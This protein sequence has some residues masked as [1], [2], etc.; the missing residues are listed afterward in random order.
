MSES[1]ALA[2]D[3][4]T[5]ESPDRDRGIGRYT[6]GLIGG[7]VETWGAP[8]HLFGFGEVCPYSGPG[9][10]DGRVIYHR[11]P[12]SIDRARWLEHGVAAPLARPVEGAART[13]FLCTSPA[14]PDVLIPRSAACLTGCILYDL[15]PLI[16]RHQQ[17]DILPPHLWEGYEQRLRLA[18]RMDFA[19]AIS[20]NT[21]RDAIARLDWPEPR[22]RNI[23]TGVESRFFEPVEEQAIQRALKNCGIRP[24]FIL[25]VSGY[26]PRKNWEGALAAYAA[27]PKDLRREYRFALVC[28]LTESQ[29][30][31]VLDEAQ[32]L[33][34]AKSVVITGFVSDADLPALYRGAAAFLFPSLYEGFGIP[35]AEAMACGCPTL[36]ADNSSLPEVVGDCGWM[37]DARD[38]QALAATL[39]EILSNRE[40]TKRKI[41][42]ALERAQQ[43]QWDAVAQRCAEALREFA[44]NA[45]SSLESLNRI[46]SN[47]AQP[48]P[49]VSSSHEDRTFERCYS[50][51]PNLFDR[52]GGRG[53]CPQSPARTSTTGESIQ[54][55]AATKGLFLF[56]QREYAT[57]ARV[58]WLR[59]CLTNIPET[60]RGKPLFAVSRDTDLERLLR[61][62]ETNGGWLWLADA[63][64]DFALRRLERDGMNPAEWQ[65]APEDLRGD[66]RRHPLIQRLLELA[67]GFTGSPEMLEWFGVRN[68]QCVEWAPTLTQP[69]AAVTQTSVLRRRVVLGDFSHALQPALLEELERY[70]SELVCSAA[71][72]QSSECGTA[73]PGCAERNSKLKE[74]P[75]YSAPDELIFIGEVRDPIALQ[76]LYARRNRPRLAERV[77]IM[78]A[79]NL[80]KMLE[81]A[82][83]AQETIAPQR[84]GFTPDEFYAQF[85]FYS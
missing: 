33:G 85:S 22:I 30:E 52:D 36:V 20:D 1:L 37:A 23:G 50:G 69:R 17:P 70:A 13:V 39:T 83:N 8:L 34:V 24:P 62:L 72:L 46:S 40:Q 41:G 19:L 61:Q 18:R 44:A 68:R 10:D 76:P 57:G 32:R 21:R 4:Q 74:K 48:P 38:P 54:R 11:Y 43:F 27:L 79:S 53:D 64:L 73:A 55:Q 26:N 82:H 2:L 12:D 15:I 67:Q 80:T 56:D 71:L 81:A 77:R 75:D 59:E 78:P 35:A 47:V 63:E 28:H 14:M 49:A 45:G 42:A 9:C 51:P 60:L 7:L 6:S 29:R 3:L 66:P 58:E 84:P 5:L 65:A 31:R 25:C 16:F